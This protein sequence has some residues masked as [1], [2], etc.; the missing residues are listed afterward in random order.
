MPSAASSSFLS[1][2]PSVDAGGCSAATCRIPPTRLLAVAMPV[3]AALL[4]MISVVEPEVWAEGSEWTELLWLVLVLSLEVRGPPASTSA[5]TAACCCVAGRR[6]ETLQ[7]VTG[8]RMKKVSQSLPA[9]KK[10]LT[11]HIQQYKKFIQH[12]YQHYPNA[13]LQIRINYTLLQSLA[14]LPRPCRGGSAQKM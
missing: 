11:V 2:V 10:S 12:R 4:A 5:R 14:A 1:V 8:R 13:Q 9:R 7:G 6:V 3:P